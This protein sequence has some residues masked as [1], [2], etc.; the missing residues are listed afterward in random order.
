[1]NEHDSRREKWMNHMTFD[2]RIEIFLLHD[3]SNQFWV[4]YIFRFIDSIFYAFKKNYAF[5]PL[6]PPAISLFGWANEV[7][8]WNFYCCIQNIN[9]II[10]D[11]LDFHAKAIITTDMKYMKQH[12]EYLKSN[13]CAISLLVC[14]STLTLSRAR[15][16]IKAKKEFNFDASSNSL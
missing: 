12:S 1:M 11:S 15:F 9:N 3:I 13:S 7:V 5:F 6:L 4:C 10:I 8:S 14:L 16:V 2:F